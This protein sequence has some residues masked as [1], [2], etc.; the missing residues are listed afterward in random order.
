MDEAGWSASENKYMRQ[1]VS[2]TSLTALLLHVLLGCCSHHAH[3]QEPASCT[4]AEV[5]VGHRCCQHSPA[6]A[7]ETP[8]EPGE[9][10]HETHC[11]FASCAKV[12]LPA[13]HLTS[14]SLCEASCCASALP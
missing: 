13:H 6:P 12:E 10:C 1:L 4:H 7:K 11:V 5:A 3:A 8:H 9:R 14:I 2:I